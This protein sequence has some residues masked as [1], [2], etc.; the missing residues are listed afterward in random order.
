L[1]KIRTG[2]LTKRP[3][4]SSVPVSVSPASMDPE[5]LGEEGSDDFDEQAQTIAQKA[6]HAN[7]KHASFR[8]IV[9]PLISI[10][11]P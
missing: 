11:V 3:V 10:L 4:G 1:E 9:T 7:G 8:L 6:S 5:S 2:S